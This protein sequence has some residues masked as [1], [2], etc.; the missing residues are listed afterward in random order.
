MFGAGTACVI[1]PVKDILYEN[2]VFHRI[3][4][5]TVLLRIK[6]SIFKHF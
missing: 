6:Y 2:Q 1:C 5:T 3:T 4:I